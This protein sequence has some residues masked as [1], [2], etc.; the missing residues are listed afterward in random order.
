M[1]SGD[2]NEAAPA[3]AEVSEPAVTAAVASAAAKSEQR[4]CTR[5]L[6]AATAATSYTSMAQDRSTPNTASV[7]P[8]PRN[9]GTHSDRSSDPHPGELALVGRQDAL[10]V[11]AAKH[12]LDHP[13]ELRSYDPRGDHHAVAG[14]R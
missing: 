12:S 1:H 13:A 11:D 9:T 6:F 4:R 10:V 5:V 2:G 7:R 8:S 3:G 14:D